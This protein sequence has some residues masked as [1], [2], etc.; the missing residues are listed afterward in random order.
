[1]KES[2]SVIV[3]VYKTQRYLRKC[4]DSILNPTYPNIEIVVVNDCSPDDS[5]EICREYAE[6][7]D[8]VKYIELDRNVGLSSARNAGSL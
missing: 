1:M 5:G 7:Y 3:P 2:I 4:L 6:K 8:Q